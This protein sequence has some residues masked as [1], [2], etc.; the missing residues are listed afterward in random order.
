MLK[1]SQRP[2]FF[3]PFLSFLCLNIIGYTGCGNSDS[4]LEAENH[5]ATASFSIK[6]S[7]VAADLIARVEV[8]V[9]GPDMSEIRQDLSK[10]GDIYTGVFE[11]PAGDGRSFT[12]NG[13]DANGVLIYTGTENADIIVEERE[14]V[15]I[16]MRR[17]S[18]S[19][20]DIDITG[21]LSDGIDITGTLSP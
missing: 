11:V 10:Q 17:I 19:A 13:Y 8:V 15:K 16:T 6:L 2:K 21:T 5:T 1:L 9:T 18:S 4:P 14:Q 12:L 20:G 3:R 7:K